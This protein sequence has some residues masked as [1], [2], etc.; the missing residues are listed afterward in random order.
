MSA[1][2]PADPEFVVDLRDG[3]H[4]DDRGGPSPKPCPSCGE[5]VPRR[6]RFCTDYCRTALPR[7]R[8]T[9]ADVA[10]LRALVSAT[11]AGSQRAAYVEALEILEQRAEAR[12]HR[13][14]EHRLAQPVGR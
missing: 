3:T 12:S 9:A 2:A 6:R 7:I 11:P 14:A 4:P 1:P 5:P 10:R 8:R 13:L